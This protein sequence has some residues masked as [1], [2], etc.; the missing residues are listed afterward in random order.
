MAT[1][2]IR[3]DLVVFCT[4]Y[5]VD[6][7]WLGEEYPRYRDEKIDVREICSSEDISLSVCLASPPSPTADSHVLPFAVHW[8]RPSRSRC[9]PANRRTASHAL[10]SSP[11]QQSPY[12]HLCPSL[13]THRQQDCSNHPRSRSFRVHVDSCARYRIFSWIV[14][15][16]EGV[17]STR[18][19]LLLVS[20]PSCPSL[21]T[22]R[23]SES[24]LEYLPS[25][26]RRSFGAAFVSFY[27]LTGPFADPKMAKIVKTEL[28][29]TI[30][31]RGLLGNLFMGA[32]RLITLPSLST[33]TELTM[34]VDP[35]GVLRS[36]ERNRITYRNYLGLFLGAAGQSCWCR[37]R[38]EA[39]GVCRKGC[40]VIESCVPC[41]YS[42]SHFHLRLSGPLDFWDFREWEAGHGSGGVEG[43]RMHRSQ[44]R[45][46]RFLNRKGN[47]REPLN[48]VD[49]KLETGQ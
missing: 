6:A 21:A 13:S 5:K 49:S 43:R 22:A 30:C 12:P 14:S 1:K 34:S 19:L 37:C 4:G 17:R 26:T 31:R 20:H 42:V 29:E 39:D 46:H 44:D 18:P 3:P 36:T 47:R 48:Y 7:S 41:Q 23:R 2:E 8:I 15:A 35:H 16:L 25:L 9:N 24:A 28:W 40:R 11:P 33:G 45:N 27:R 32:V 38:R 10:D